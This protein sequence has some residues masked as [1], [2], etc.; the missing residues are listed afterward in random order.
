MTKGSCQ[1]LID[2]IS[3]NNGN[4]GSKIPVVA[5]FTDPAVK[6]VKT[7]TGPTKHNRK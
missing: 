5:I 3:T 2:T 7:A 6:I 4:F 1:G